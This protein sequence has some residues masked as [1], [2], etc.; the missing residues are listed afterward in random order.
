MTRG[1]TQT[2]NIF[3]QYTA[4]ESRTINCMAQEGK[5]EDTGGK[6]KDTGGKIKT[7]GK[8]SYI[9]PQL[10]YSAQKLSQ[11][12]IVFQREKYDLISLLHYFPPSTQSVRV[13]KLLHG[14]RG[15]NSYFFP[16]LDFC[17]LFSVTIKIIEEKYDIMSPMAGI[18]SKFPIIL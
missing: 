1:K 6:N 5:N 9:F 3:P 8:I 17:A 12:K 7:G 15:K 2:K 13:E 14:L 11:K 18:F 16:Q 10:K 4:R